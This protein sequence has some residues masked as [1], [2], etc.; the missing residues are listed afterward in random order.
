METL[1]MLRSRTTFTLLIFVPAMQVLLFG[2]AIRPVPPRIGVAIAAP[3]AAG[4][5]RVARAIERMPGVTM[6]GA[7][8]KPGG[9][10]S[11]VREGRALIG[12]E[13]PSLRSFAN[14][15]QARVPL[16]IVVDATNAGLTGAAVSGI[17]AAYWRSLAEQADA[18]D[19]GPGLKIERLYNPEARADWTFLPALIGVTV[20][21]AMIM[22]GA[23]SL[24]RERESGT[25]EGLQALPVWPVEMLLGKLLP[26][27]LIGTMQGLLVLGVGIALFALPM[28]GSVVALVALL[29]LFAAANFALGYAISMRA[30]TQVAALQGAVAFYLPAMLLS[31]FLYPFETLPNWARWIG[32][33]FPLT[34]FIRAAR[35]ALL[36]GD[37]AAAVLAHGWPILAF[38]IAASA[39]ALL[40][41]SR[42]ID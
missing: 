30:R 29:P 7:P 14:P 25:W 28:R 5:G 21:I 36:H 37:G 9:A 4:A 35:G 15:T 40:A 6:T 16:R 13:V 10:A 42:S 24:A 26:Y 2:Y 39:V 22:L 33:L 12:I 31:G 3:T 32:T 38:L 18:V 27:V 41:R 1:R 11:A 23:L 8:L 34:H 20:M 17:E 19:S